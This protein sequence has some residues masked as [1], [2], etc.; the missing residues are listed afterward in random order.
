[1]KFGVHWSSALSLRAIK[2]TQGLSRRTFR[3]AQHAQWFSLTCSELCALYQNQYTLCKVY[4]MAP[5]VGLEPTT[6]RLTA[7]RST[8]ELLGN[9]KCLGTKLLRLK[10]S[11]FVISATFPSLIWW[12]RV[13][14][15]LCQW[16]KLV[17]PRWIEHLSIGSKPR[18]IT[19][20][21]KSCL[22]LVGAL[23]NAPSS[24]S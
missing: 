2:L 1:M 13:N 5:K 16:R 12:S 7:G 23:G 3:I 19:V 15:S 11:F 6:Y 24:A 22:K 21:R 9:W 10:N 14:S 8:I 18:V 17:G 20:I 4:K